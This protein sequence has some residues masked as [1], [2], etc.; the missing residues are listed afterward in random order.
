MYLSYVHNTEPPIIM[1]LWSALGSASACIGRHAYL[2]TGIGKVYANMFILL[3]GAPGTRKG[4]ALKYSVKLVRKYT[5]VRFAPDDTGGQRQGLI[6]ALQD[7]YNKSIK[8]NNTNGGNIDLSNITDLKSLGDININLNDVDRY[9]L[10]A[11]ASEFSTFMGHG[12]ALLAALLNKVWDGEPYNYQLK[13][14]QKTLDDSLMSIVGCTTPSEIA[15]ILPT[16][17]IGQGFMSRWVLVFAAKQE[18]KVSIDEAGV[19]PVVGAQIGE[20]YSWLYNDLRGNITLNR[21]ASKLQKDI[22]MA[23]KTKIA[24]SRFMHY[25]DRRHT[26]MLKT[27]IL[28]ATLRRSNVIGKIDIEMGDILLRLTEDGMPNALGEFGLSPLSSAKQKLLEFLQHAGEAVTLKILWTTMSNDMKMSDFKLTLQEFVIKKKIVEVNLNASIAYM[29]KDDLSNL[30]EDLIND[31]KEIDIVSS[32]S[33][34]DDSDDSDDNLEIK[35][36]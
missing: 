17:S 15:R 36:E 2:Q 12:D 30:W 19:C 1:H 35:Y 33:T 11:A 8:L 23:D 5:Q 18:K 26:H 14:E 27:A 9:C 31:E 20:I 4:H 3:V 10:Y 6:A 29:Y 28:L 22:Y 32:T 21:E 24:D 13:N 25:L 7:T 34:N 16:E